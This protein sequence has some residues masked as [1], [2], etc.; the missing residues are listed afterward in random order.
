[1]HLPPFRLERYFAK[2]EF[3]T[4]FLLCSSDCEALSI[5]DV[6]ALEPDGAE[7]LA[8]CWL[9][10]TET[11]GS[12]ALRQAIQTLYTTIQPEQIL[13]HSGAEE[14]IFLCMHAMLKP[15]D[16]VI[17]HTPSY[18]SLTEIAR[19]IGC[20]ISAWQADP[21][22]AWQLDLNDLLKLLR[23]TTK[24]IVINTPHN[25]TG[26]LMPKPQFRAL[27]ELAEAHKIIV[28][29]DEVYREAEYDPTM[30]LPAACDLSSHAVSLGVMS[31]TYGLPG[32]RIGW[33]A[34]RNT[35]LYERVAILKD[36]TTICNSAPSE[37]LATIALRQRQTLVERNLGII[38]ANLALLDEFFSNHQNRFAWKRPHAGPIA[39]PRLLDG[40]VEAFCH[41][42]VSKSGVLLLPG[43][44]YDDPHNCFRIGFGRRNLPEALMRF[45]TFLA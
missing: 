28:F 26:Y 10:Y 1:M 12:P 14:A 34:T 36:Y 37:L 22:N 23:P 8:H 32:L 25:P 13:V 4:E 2:Y 15:D 33:I 43:T 41:D 9:G 3:A 27:L 17:V 21:H 5:G 30:R 35:A 24:L 20:D 29:S 11:Q 45:A 44:L 16:H 39:F 38:R 6:V 42:L 40:Q 18:Q 19:S 7:Q 31:K